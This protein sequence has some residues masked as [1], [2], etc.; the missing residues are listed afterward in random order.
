MMDT[1]GASTQDFQPRMQRGC[2]G[3]TQMIKKPWSIYEIGAVVGGLAVFWPIGLVALFL[4]MKKGEIWKGASEM[5]APWSNWQK[6]SDTVSNFAGKW[7]R[8]ARSFETGNRAFDEYRSA[9]IAELEALRRKLDDER[10][11]FDEFLT[12][13]RH[14]KDKEDFE[15]F[16][17]DR[18]AQKSE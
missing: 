12:K 14:A 3:G 6:T 16:M 13:L 18:T 8:G 7:S 4:K 17:A 15:R 1:A 11:E 10:R 9:K 2:C 5:E